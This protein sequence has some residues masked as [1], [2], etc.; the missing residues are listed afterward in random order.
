MIRFRKFIDRFTLVLLFGLGTA[1]LALGGGAIVL[2]L[3]L[4]PPLG[5]VAALLVLFLP[6]AAI[7]RLKT[8]RWDTQPLILTLIGIAP[9]FYILPDHIGYA[10]GILRAGLIALL[11]ADVLAACLV[12]FLRVTSFTYDEG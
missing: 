5:V 10:S 7:H 1:H 3:M 2:L 4:V 9:L 12:I 11:A 8:R 6:L